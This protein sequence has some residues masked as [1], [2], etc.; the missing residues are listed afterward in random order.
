MPPAS[1]SI[2][3]QPP[4]LVIVTYSTVPIEKELFYGS[5]QA[6]GTSDKAKLIHV[7]AGIPLIYENGL[8]W[9]FRFRTVANAIQRELMARNEQR[10]RL[11]NNVTWSQRMIKRFEQL[12]ASIVVLSGQIF[13]CNPMSLREVAIAAWGRPLRID[14][15]TTHNVQVPECR[16]VCRL[17]VGHFNHGTRNECMGASILHGLVAL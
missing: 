10:R 2:A 3:S 7:G 14:W 17:S 4:N 13:C 8:N 15:W 1:P 12:N 5:L 16:H 11:C 6:Q 9:M